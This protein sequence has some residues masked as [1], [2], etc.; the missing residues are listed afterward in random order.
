MDQDDTKVEVIYEEDKSL[1]QCVLH[2][3][4]SWMYQAVYILMWPRIKSHLEEWEK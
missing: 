2:F 1:I 3:L 4:L